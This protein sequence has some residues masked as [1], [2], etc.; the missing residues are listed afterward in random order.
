[1]SRKQNCLKDARHTKTTNTNQLKESPCEISIESAIGKREK[2][3]LKRRISDLS[4]KTKG[5]FQEKIGNSKKK[6]TLMSNQSSS[7]TNSSEDTM[8][9]SKDPSIQELMAQDEIIEQSIDEMMGWAF[10]LQKKEAVAAE[11]CNLC[12]FQLLLSVTKEQ[13]ENKTS[14]ND[15]KDTW[16]QSKDNKYLATLIPTYSIPTLSDD[17]L[18]PTSFRFGRHHSK[19]QI[20]AAGMVIITHVEGKRYFLMIVEPRDGIPCLNFAGRSM[21]TN[22]LYAYQT[23]LTQFL[24]DCAGLI[25]PD[26]VKALAEYV[27]PSNTQ[28]VHVLDAKYVLY[29]V[30]ATQLS[31]PR[32]YCFPQLS[33]SL[34]AATDDERRFVWVSAF[35]LL[36]MKSVSTKN[37]ITAFAD[38]DGVISTIP[39]SHEELSGPRLGTAPQEIQLSPVLRIYS[40]KHR[41]SWLLPPRFAQAH[42]GRRR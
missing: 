42:Y 26:E 15:D 28:E 38:I 5:D 41:T 31:W 6:C 40:G 18:F 13:S 30:D 10:S 29:A 21:E 35:D 27:H 9:Q 14:K 20:S 1:M 32:L 37:L 25:R 34:K 8:N 39:V 24:A 7:R 22:D 12:G 17:L 11:K 2:S 4:H 33:N 36:K 23:G 3:G 19:Q 16:N